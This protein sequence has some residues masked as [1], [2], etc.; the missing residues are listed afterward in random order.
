MLREEGAVQLG[1]MGGPV[2]NPRKAVV[3]MHSANVVSFRRSLSLHHA[4]RGT[5]T[6]Q[7]RRIEIG[8]QL[9]ADARESD[10][11]LLARPN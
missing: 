11:D 9:E 3:Q 5:P 2:T 6:D 10:D 8:K 1:G 7:A 4:S